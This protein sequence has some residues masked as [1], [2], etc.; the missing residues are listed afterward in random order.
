[1]TATHFI[2][3]YRPEHEWAGVEVERGH[4]CDC[5]RWF[6]QWVVSQAFLD[7][8]PE[9]RR[10]VFL[11]SCEVVRYQK[12]QAAWFPKQCG[13]CERRQITTQYVLKQYA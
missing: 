5:G 1:M 9:G 12:G 11:A 3:R 10:E 13:Q 6:P 7:S 4:Q 2:A 8:M